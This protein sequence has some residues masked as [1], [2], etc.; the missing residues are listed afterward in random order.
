MERAI[1]KALLEMGEKI[2]NRIMKRWGVIHN[3]QGKASA[4]KPQVE[5]IVN[6][7]IS[8]HLSYS[9]QKAW[10]A[11]LGRGSLMNT[12]KDNIWS[13]EYVTS[14]VFNR[15]RLSPLNR[16]AKKFSIV[17]REPKSKYRDLDGST[18]IATDAF[19]QEGFNLE[20]W[21]ERHKTKPY[22]KYFTPLPPYKIIEDEIEMA[23]PEIKTA[24]ENAVEEYVKKKLFG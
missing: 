12:R 11:E 5:K 24:I 6:N 13:K 8:L 15:A 3:I 14:S 4:K 21:A 1:K 2:N 9:G 7:I 20:Y 18:H 23:L 17:S 10:I 16:Y 19:P 22:R